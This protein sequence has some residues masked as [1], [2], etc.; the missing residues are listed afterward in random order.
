MM[1]RESYRALFLILLSA[2]CTSY[3]IRNA[4]LDVAS[5]SEERID[6]AIRSLTSYVKENPRE[7]E[8][9]LLLAE[10]YAARGRVGLE[11]G[12]SFLSQARPGEAERRAEAALGDLRRARSTLKEYYLRFDS[13][14]WRKGKVLEHRISSLEVS[15]AEVKAR[16]ERKKAQAYEKLD[17]AER[18]FRRRPAEAPSCLRLAEEAGR[19]A[20]DVTREAEEKKKVWAAQAAREAEKK[21]C[22]LRDGALF[23]PDD[24]EPLRAS[25]LWS[26]TAE[27]LRARYGLGRA[28]TITASPSPVA[29]SALLEAIRLRKEGNALEFPF[30]IQAAEAD[31]KCAILAAGRLRKLSGNAS[32]NLKNRKA[33]ESYLEESSV[34]L[35]N[36]L[37]RNDPVLSSLFYLRAEGAAEALDRPLPF[38]AGRARNRIRRM[39]SLKAAFVLDPRLSGRERE[40]AQSLVDRIVTKLRREIPGVLITP[41]EEADLEFV[42][43]SFVSGSNTEAGS[44]ESLTSYVKGVRTYRNPDYEELKR[45]RDYARSEYEKAC[46]ARDY[47]FSLGNPFNAQRWN[48]EAMRR[49][50]QYN[51][52]VSK[53]N[54]TPPIYRKVVSRPYTY[55]RQ[56]WERSAWVRLTYRIADKGGRGA[57]RTIEKRTSVTS[58][59]VWGVSEDDASGL[60][61]REP[62]LK[63]VALLISEAQEKAENAFF[64]IVKRTCD[65][66]GPGRFLRVAAAAAEAGDYERA[67]AALWA[68]SE[69]SGKGS[70]EDKRWSRWLKAVFFRSVPGPDDRN[71]RMS[72]SE[73]LLSEGTLRKFTETVLKRAL[74]CRPRAR[75]VASSMREAF[76]TLYRSLDSRLSYLLVC[77]GTRE[78]DSVCPPP[79]RGRREKEGAKLIAEYYLKKGDW[80][81][82]LDWKLLAALLPPSDPDRAWSLLATYSASLPSQK[83][84]YGWLQTVARL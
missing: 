58:E 36:S 73:A 18:I 15:L 16:A 3:V 80:R 47:Y 13:E 49:A 4:R 76:S 69:L 23:T 63:P 24:A 71:A 50:A 22:G 10:A 9:F 64:E 54:S 59:R 28:G 34:W 17:R 79:L 38:D 7:R 57:F 31:G 8:A 30:L 65:L 1:G 60:S 6:S 55:N 61:N 70:R 32:R 77:A 33:L 12:R 53:L 75:S 43:A 2:G 84:P 20:R 78:G 48:L 21:A 44:T 27:L 5:G 14:A 25:L 11:K 35:E 82:Q 45:M 42:I 37:K 29:L 83:W 62:H 68:H 40:A 56:S 26:A 52:V 46:R 72:L 19:T 51:C 41:R 74:D 66:K 81:A 67:A 39:L